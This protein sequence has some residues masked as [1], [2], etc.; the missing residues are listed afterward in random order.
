MNSQQRENIFG[1]LGVSLLI[2]TMFSPIIWLV[3]YGISTEAYYREHGTLKSTAYISAMKNTGEI[4]GRFFLGS[5]SI[6]ENQYYYYLMKVGNG[7]KMVK[8][9]VDRTVVFEDDNEIPRIET[10][11]IMNT[12]GAECYKAYIPNGSILYEY[13]IQLP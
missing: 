5:G 7:H 13:N 9:P 6:S 1:I 3:W 2:L 8:V 4:E 10:H 12:L 11:H